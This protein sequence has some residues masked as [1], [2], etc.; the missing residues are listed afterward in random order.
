MN[1]H[2]IQPGTAVLANFDG[3]E[4]ENPKARFFLPAYHDQ[5]AVP[6][7]A[8]D[9]AADGR[10]LVQCLVGAEQEFDEWLP[11]ERVQLSQ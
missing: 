9:R 10:V 7:Y 2:V 1:R 6:G 5:S 8:R 3:W 11:P 4:P